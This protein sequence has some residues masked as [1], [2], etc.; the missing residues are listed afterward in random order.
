MVSSR[1][2]VVKALALLPW[3]TKLALPHS[4]KR[5]I[6]D[7]QDRR[8][9]AVCR[10]PEQPRLDALRDQPVLVHQHGRNVY[11]ALPGRESTCLYRTN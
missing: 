5:C 2:T 11:L 6:A 4:R 10:H 7:R 1:Q 3:D 8:E 9:A